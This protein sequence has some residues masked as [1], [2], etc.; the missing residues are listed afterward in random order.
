MPHPCSLPHAARCAQIQSLLS[1]IRAEND[2][3]AKEQ[4]KKRGAKRKRRVRAESGED[5]VARTEAAETDDG[6]QQVGVQQISVTVAAK[7]AL[8]VAAQVTRSYVFSRA[9]T[10]MY[11][12]YH[13]S[14]C[15]LQPM[16]CACISALM[17]T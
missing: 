6:E 1:E 9:Y 7:S 4:P 5:G 11:P 13:R 16:P 12:V 3:W 14:H 17:H 2:R 8:R 15:A 10:T